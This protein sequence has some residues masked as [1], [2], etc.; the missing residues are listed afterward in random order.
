[1]AALSIRIFFAS[2]LWSLRYDIAYL[3]HV[4]HSL[5]ELPWSSWCN[6]L[7][8]NNYLLSYLLGKK[9]D[10]SITLAHLTSVYGF[11]L[12]EVK[13]SITLV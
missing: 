8:F 5:L 12:L 1:M 2:L 6:R 4:V 11:S 13:G 3:Q 10:W 9:S 7:L